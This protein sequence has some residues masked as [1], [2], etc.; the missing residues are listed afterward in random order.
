MIPGPLLLGLVLDAA[1]DIWG[2][3]CAQEVTSCLI[4]DN[5]QAARN[6]SLFSASL[7][8]GLVLSML[9]AFTCYKMST[10]S[11]SEPSQ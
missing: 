5:E 11:K 9:L 8:V 3:S 7:A 10:R 1:C 4:Y 2:K 6:L